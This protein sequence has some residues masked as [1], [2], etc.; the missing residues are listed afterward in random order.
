[1]PPLGYVTLVHLLKRSRFVL[2]DSG[3]LQEEAPSLG[4][5]VLV[6]RETTER[7]EGVA[8]GTARVVGADRAR[9]LTEASRL[10]EDAAAYARMARAVNPY[11]D[12]R[13][14]DRIVAALMTPGIVFPRNSTGRNM[15]PGVISG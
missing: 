6:L 14:A 10:L 5:P 13:A 2:T 4:K 8:A 3:G 12:G 1:V 11:G 15:V 9:I 7:P